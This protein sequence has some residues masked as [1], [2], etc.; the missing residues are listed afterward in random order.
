MDQPPRRVAIIGAGVS[1]LTAA[2]VLS[3]R[4]HRVTLYEREAEAGGHV[5]TE[6]V[7]TGSGNLE[8]D[9]GFIVYNERTY[10]RFTRL[11][12]ELNVAT[13]RSDMSMSASCAACGVDYSTRGVRGMFARPRAIASRGHLSMLRDLFRFYGDARRTLDEDAAGQQ[14]LGDYLDSRGFGVPFRNHFLVPLAAAVWSTA[15]GQ[16]LAFPAGYLLRFLDHHGLIGYRNAV[17]WRTITGGSRSYV[18]R[19][20]SG[21]PSGTLRAGMP[22]RAVRREVDAVRVLSAAGEERFDDLVMATHAD[23]SLSLLTDADPRE[24]DALG[25][26][27]YSTNRVVLHTDASI[28]PQRRAAWASWNV[29]MPRCDRLGEALTMTYHMNRLQALDGPLAY[30]VS[31]NPGDRVADASVLVERDMAHPL[32]TFAT[33]RAQQA[34]RQIQGRR[35]TFHAGAHLGYGFHEDGCRSGWEVAD[36]ID[37]AGAD[38]RVA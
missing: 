25:G 35:R 9:T 13:Q 4:G 10:P 37:A 29:D 17:E 16:I 11:L 2:H 23:E 30:C 15:P 26:F 5:R 8:I 18:R 38:E 24:R 28:L 31:V 7:A 22:V 14:T 21:L 36:L 12:S 19:L 32:Y 27:E 3:R 34:T 1:G 20:I 6:T 33:L